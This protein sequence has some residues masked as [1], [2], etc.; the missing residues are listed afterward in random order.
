M[1]KWKL[2]VQGKTPE[3]YDLQ[4]EIGE[5]TDMAA[6][7]PEVVKQLLA[8]IKKYDTELKANVRP[9]WHREKK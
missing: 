9:A 7:N 6:E 4:A 5:T 1:G 3:L 8:L 2:R